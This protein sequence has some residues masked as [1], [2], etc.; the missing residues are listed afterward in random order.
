MDGGIDQQPGDDMR[1]L[2]NACEATVDRPTSPGRARFPDIP[3]TRCAASGSVG[4]TGAIAAVVAGGGSPHP[5]PGGA[6]R[7]LTVLLIVGI[8]TVMPCGEA[9]PVEPPRPNILFVLTDDQ[10]A[11]LLGCMGNEVI[12]TPAMDRLAAEGTLFTHAF[13][14]TAICCSSRASILT[15][16]YMRRHGIRDFDTPLSAAAFAET[17][18]ALLRAAGYRTGY[19]GKF[20]IGAPEGTGPSLALPADRFDVWRG[21]PQDV[22]FRQVV[23]GEPR[24]LTTVLE[25]EAVRFLRSQ[26]ADRPFCLTVGLKEP[27]GPWDYFDPEVADAYQDRHIPPPATRTLEDY[28]SQPRFIRESLSGGLTPDTIASP[29]AYQHDMRLVYRLVSRADLALGRIRNALETVGLADNTVIIVSSDHGSMG[30][31][32]GLKGKWLMYE[33]SIRVPLIIHDPRVPA[34]HRGQR[35]G[36]AALNIDIAPTILTLAGVTIPASMQGLDLSPLVRGEVAVPWRTSWYYEHVFDTER[37]LRPVVRSEGVREDDWKYIRYPAVVP[38]AE[39][40]FD[41]R[42]DPRETH[43]LAADP[44]HA[45]TLARLRTCC[46]A[47][48]RSL[49]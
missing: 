8:A 30:G 10:P 37:P 35:C 5:A 11:G 13:V 36:R 3:A 15:G 4:S 44:G 48:R 31:A 38:P 9:S 41:L 34:A 28:M 46:D 18:P 16:Q 1:A 43:D 47:Y 32:H 20:A 22:G 26:P 2:T 12:Q 19:V 29:E 7:R 17:Y 33:E 40:L 23:D 45:E 42:N 39:Q 27:H 49:E 14:T 25:E 6:C 21:F 24:Y